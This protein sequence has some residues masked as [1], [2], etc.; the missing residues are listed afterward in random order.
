M[1]N[2]LYLPVCRIHTTGQLLKKAPVRFKGKSGAE[3]RWLERQVNDPFVK[4]A[5]LQHFRC[6]SAFKLLEIDEKHRLLKP[7]L[8]VIDCGAAPGA[9]SQVAVQRVNSAGER[10]DLARGYVFGVDLLHI[11]P[12]QGAHFLSNCDITSPATHAELQ[13]LL[14]EAYADI[15]LSD[16]APN[17]TGVRELDHERLVSMCLSLLDLAERLLRPGG[18]LLC[19]YWDGALTHKLR[20][21]LNRAF[22]DVKTVKPKASRKESAELYFLARTFRKT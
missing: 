1:W 18:S 6:R 2:C 20:D 3:Q 11:A 7:G 4:A 17:A 13:K 19:K 8:S 16:M 12:L 9:W 21:G 5:H 14:P 10:P 22:Q 15:I